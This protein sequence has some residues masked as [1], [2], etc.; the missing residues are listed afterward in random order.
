MEPGLNT[1]I[2][3]GA[4]LPCWVVGVTLLGRGIPAAGEEDFAEPIRPFLQ[5]YCV[6]CHGE[7]KTEGGA[8]LR[9]LTKEIDLLKHR[10]LWESAVAQVESGDMPPKG[11]SPSDE[12]R[13]EFSNWI[14]ARFQ[15]VD[16]SKYRSAGHVTMPRLTKVEYRNT[17]RD[18][19]GVDLK[20]GEDLPPD[21]EGENGFTNDRDSL[22]LTAAQLEQYFQAAETAI[23]GVFALAK[24]PRS[25]SF[26][27]EAM[28]RSPAKLQPERNGVFLIHPDHELKAEWEFPVDGWYEFRLAAAVI[29]A[30]PCV[31]EVR[32]DGEVVASAS[33]DSQEAS[34]PPV[35][36]A[37]GLVRAGRHSVSLQSRNLVPQTPEPP[38]IVRIIDE[39]ARERAPRLA[40]IGGVESPSVRE[41]R[42]D[43][44]LK[45]WGI[46]E[47]YEWLRFLGPEGDPRKID[48]R[49]VYLE[50]RQGKWNAVRNQLAK[51]AGLTVAQIDLAWEAQ[52]RER[53]AENAAVLAGVA[54]VKWD[55]WMNWQ[56]K[57]LVD[58]LEI[59]GPV[60]PSIMGGEWT[61]LDALNRGDAA[62]EEVL[63]EFLIRAFRR[64]LSESDLGRYESLLRR[65]QTGEETRE[66][67]LALTLSAILSSPKFLYRD[68]LAK[69]A[70]PKGRERQL[71]GFEIASRLSYFL[72]QSSPDAELYDLA[73]SGLLKDPAVLEAQANRLIEHLKADS[74]FR[75][76]VFDWFAIRELGA[77]ISPDLSKYPEFTAELA[78]EMREEAVRTVAALFREDRPVSDLIDSSKAYLNESLARHYGIGGV[79][80]DEM[81]PVTLRDRRRGGI[82]G[83]GSVLVATASPARTNPV[84]RGAWVLERL[85]GEDPG[86]P[87]P[88]AGVLP[89]D[90][91]EARGFTLR[92][93]L[94]LHRTRL[95]CARC[96]DRIDPIGFG[97]ENYDAIG[98]WRENE[99]GK[100]VDASGR[101]PDGREFSGPMELKSILKERREEIEEN[102]LRRLLAFA[103]GREL[104]YFDDP[105]VAELRNRWQGRDATARE[106][107][108][109]VVT[110]EPFRRQAPVE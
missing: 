9:G 57:L 12:E 76:F 92:E 45:A 81:R 59:F 74:F 94:A 63:R 27:A 71:D 33:V 53:L 8:D 78:D 61:L 75:E 109:A 2:I 88:T 100:P 4:I 16:W 54:E 29:G 72:W 38:D 95:D 73:S 40:A 24:P 34:Q 101:F 99:A 49:R 69:E 67:A 17:L 20:A 25:L 80:G 41:A 105:T 86:E 64:P 46:Q 37:T 107:I 68:E 103:L 98:R 89:G 77:G 66:E 85:L 51:V 23:D 58:R 35:I 3:R 48:L 14:G 96:H 43:L 87:L 62:P 31:A 55:D 10:E 32:I 44:N 50:E 42:E 5:Q 70:D 21:G 108:L 13:A 91:G 30:K 11:K 26:E 15:G 1:R 65:F 84:R 102:L 83:M 56:G 6:R 82:L 104:H 18:L 110:S 22:S 39:R 90:A 93:E 47:C 106:L 19:L 60:R 52:N 79:T 28:E 7:E 36:R 97:L